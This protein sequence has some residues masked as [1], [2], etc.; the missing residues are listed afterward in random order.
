M[1]VELKLLVLCEAGF[2]SLH[3]Q[4]SPLVSSNNISIMLCLKALVF[5]GTLFAVCIAPNKAV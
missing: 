2:F 5:L 4:L 1:R 3:D